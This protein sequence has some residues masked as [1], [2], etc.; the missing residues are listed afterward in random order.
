M[1][2]LDRTRFVLRWDAAD[3]RPWIIDGRQMGW[4]KHNLARRLAD[5]PG[6]FLV[7]ERAVVLHPQLA[8]FDQR[9][10]R[11][12]EVCQALVESGHLA[13][14]RGEPFPLLR[15]WQEIPLAA[16]DRAAAPV[17]GI[18]NY[19][20]HLNGIVRSRRGLQMWVGKRAMSKATAPGKLDHLVAGGQPLGLSPWQNLIKEC[21]EEAGLDAALVAKAKPA[22]AL[23]YRCRF[24]D[25]QRDDVLF[26]YD[27]ELPEGWQPRSLDG[28]VESF[29]LMPIEEVLARLRA[30]DDFKFNVALVIIDFLIREGLV[31]PDEPGFEEIIATLHSGGG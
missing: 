25:G 13:R 27:L 10:A 8:G 11:L 31:G 5:F 4:M 29:Q 19:G 14:L 1:S 9:T 23:S 22:G 18:R 6:T 2:L 30:G 3:Y 12:L 21:H 20:V 26:C 24:T 15:S 16:L 7:S 17:F 28:E